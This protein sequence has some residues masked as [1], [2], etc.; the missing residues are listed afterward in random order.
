[1]QVGQ[2]T[3]LKLTVRSDSGR[4]IDDLQ[5]V[6]GAF[7]ELVG[8][9]EDYR[10]ITRFK[11]LGELPKSAAD[12]GGPTLEFSFKPEKAGYIKIFGQFRIN[13]Q[14]VKA[15]FG[16]SVDPE[17]QAYVDDE[18]WLDE[19]PVRASD[20][21]DRERPSPAASSA[22][23]KG[24]ISSLLGNTPVRTEGSSRVQDDLDDL[25]VEPERGG[26]AEVYEDQNKKAL[27]GWARPE[28][29]VEFVDDS[30]DISDESEDGPARLKPVGQ[31]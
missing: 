22:P 14:V 10:T 29:D 9:Y 28:P 27:G 11:P 3:A 17:V 21:E 15:S 30:E 18:D 19:E 31:F 7:G 1:M 5:P 16:M 23:V 26:K 4:Y 6:T 12:T 20:S 24:D 2:E 25:Y 8:V 13:D